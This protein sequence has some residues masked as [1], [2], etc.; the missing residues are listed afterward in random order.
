M[1]KFLIEFHSRVQ[2][3]ELYFG[4]VAEIDKVKT[5]NQQEAILF[6]NQTQ[7]VVNHDL[8]KIL[9]ANCYLL[10]Y[11]LIESSI[12]NG[13]VAI[14]DAIHDEKLGYSEINSD[15]QKI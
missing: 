2:Q 11:N 10:L 5:D 9:K 8:Q 7:Y 4:F 14:Y 1:K 6:P 13:I 12:R 15:I 3:I